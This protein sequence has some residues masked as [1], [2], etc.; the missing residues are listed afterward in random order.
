M[1]KSHIGSEYK[2][3]KKKLGIRL[4]WRN[5]YGNGIVRS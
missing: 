1:S 4:D 2:K 5:G 3:E